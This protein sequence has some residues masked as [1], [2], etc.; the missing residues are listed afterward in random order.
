M[1]SSSCGRE[2][3]TL[4]FM[5]T[6]NANNIGIKLSYEASYSN[7]HFLDLEIFVSNK[8]LVTKTFFKATDRNRYIPVDSCHHSAWL[9][10]MPRSQFLWIR[11]NCTDLRDFYHQAD[12][13]K[14]SF[15]DR[16]YQSSDIDEEIHQISLIDRNTLISEQPKSKQDS[17]YKWSFFTTFS[18]QHRQIKNIIHKH[19]KIL[20]N[21]HL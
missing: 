10:S 6:L 21:D 4:Y 3:R 15:L 2:I 18:I 9:K 12:I 16:G 19:W 14:S 1:T 8:Q 13:L 7:I 11:R 20:K 5:S 17:L